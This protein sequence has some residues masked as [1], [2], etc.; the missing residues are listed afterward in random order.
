MVNR[1][2]YLQTG[3]KRNWGQL[4][5][6]SGFLLFVC[7]FWPIFLCLPLAVLLF[8]FF[9]L[10]KKA[11]ILT[12]S[13]NSQNGLTESASHIAQNSAFISTML[14]NPHHKKVTLN[15][16]L[17]FNWCF[18]KYQCNICFPFQMNFAIH[19]ISFRFGT[20][21]Q[22]TICY[23]YLNSQMKSFQEQLKILQRM[24]FIFFPSIQDVP[25]L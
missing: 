12:P 2:R 5:S 1:G 21:K 10:P 15:I 6:S 3:E 4:F 25:L 22:H 11:E 19:F 17:T 14:K 20:L 8:P 7:L 13:Q 23:S 16:L 18:Q 24:S 9:Y